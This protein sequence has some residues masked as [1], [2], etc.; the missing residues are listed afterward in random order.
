MYPRC[1]DARNR[2][3]FFKLLKIAQKTR[4]NLDKCAKIYNFAA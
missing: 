2:S 1:S 4:K 3:T